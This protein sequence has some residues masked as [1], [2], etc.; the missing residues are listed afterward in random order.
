MVFGI[1]NWD[2][3]ASWMFTRRLQSCK[4]WGGVSL[5]SRQNFVALPRIGFVSD[6]DYE[7]A[8]ISS[9]CVALFPS[10][11]EVGDEAMLGGFNRG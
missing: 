1:V 9:V 7:I 2:C 3:S 11:D 4:K 5:C 6:F 10:E 8:V